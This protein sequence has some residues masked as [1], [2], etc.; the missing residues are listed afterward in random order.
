MIPDVSDAIPPPRLVW[1]D[2][3]MT[4]LDPRKERIIEVATI[5]TDSELNVVAEGPEIVVHQPEEILA[6]M[7][8]WNTEHHTGSG[9]LAKVRS[10]TVDEAEAEER[11]LA[12]LAQH[13]EPG[14]SPLAGNSVWHDRR[15][16]V[17]YMPRIDSFLHYRTV[18]VSS[19]KELA[20]RWFPDAFA[21]APR[22][23][24]SHRALDDV[25]ESIV[26][27][28]YYREHVFRSPGANPPC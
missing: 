22:K 3:E 8:R 23:A 15:F 19:V 10:S 9:L 11:T 24:G 20:R 2:L 1:V 4:G 21:G 18:D 28:R 12:F 7:D 16:L 5:V 6:A 27:L 26:E 25:R 13:C 14:T 17:E